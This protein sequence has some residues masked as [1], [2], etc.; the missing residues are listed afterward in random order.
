MARGV[1]S[2]LGFRVYPL[3]R[4][5]GSGIPGTRFWLLPYYNTTGRRP[6]TCRPQLR[7]DGDCTSS[8]WYK[9]AMSSPVDGRSPSLGGSKCR[10]LL[11]LLSRYTYHFDRY[12]VS[13]TPVYT[14]ATTTLLSAP[15]A[16]DTSP[17]TCFCTC[18]VRHCCRKSW[19]KSPTLLDSHILH[20]GMP[21]W[22][23]QR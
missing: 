17:A 14:L 8:E 3:L 2:S 9:G 12:R 1:C 5:T 11:A 16:V 13:A 21:G 18:P 4:K 20:H 22:A 10:F 23:V 6:A 15:G 19:K 7:R